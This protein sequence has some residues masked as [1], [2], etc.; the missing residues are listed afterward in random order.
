MY[1]NQSENLTKAVY[2]CAPVPVRR[3]T[4][5][6]SLQHRREQASI[7]LADLEGAIKALEDNPGALAALE[8]LQK[9]GG[10]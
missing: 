9:V 10:Y 8:A 5:L 1:T 6:E 4:V 3:Q 7:H 2:E